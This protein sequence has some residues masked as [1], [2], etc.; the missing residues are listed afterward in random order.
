MCVGGPDWPS[1]NSRDIPQARCRGQAC[2]ACSLS[3]ASGWQFLWS[4]LGRGST[5]VTIEDTVFLEYA[6]SRDPLAVE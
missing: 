6:R 2:S 5:T 3:E 1:A 4:L